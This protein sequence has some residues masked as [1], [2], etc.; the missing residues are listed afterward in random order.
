MFY[1]FP[2]LFKKTP[3]FSFPSDK[4]R[5]YSQQ[6]DNKEVFLFLSNVNEVGAVA[7]R[8]RGRRSQHRVC[9]AQ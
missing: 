5:L 7:V 9:S 2:Q 8:K 1:D 4:G 3:K 6:L